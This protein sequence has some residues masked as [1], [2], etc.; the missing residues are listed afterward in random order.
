MCTLFLA[1][2]PRPD[3]SLLLLSNRDEF[4]ARPTEPAHWWPDQPELLAGRDG[5]QG[6]LWLGVNRRGRLAALTNVREGLAPAPAGAPSR[7]RLGLDCL[8]RGE[9]LHPLLDRLAEEAPVY[10]GF[11]LLLGEGDGFYWVSN[12]LP[13]ASTGH[14]ICHRLQP[15]L[16]GLS[17]GTLNEPWPKV[18]RGRAA[19]KALLEQPAL[20][21]PDRLLDL[22]MDESGAPDAEL[23]DTGVGLDHERRLAPLFIRGREYGTRS[24]TLLL[25]FP[26]GRWHWAGR[27]WGPDGAFV[28]QQQFQFQATR[29]T[30]A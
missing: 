4:H 1:L 20:P 6:G 3:L 5:L 23:P 13:G 17:N 30:R 27:E 8:T 29:E 9:G 18:R 22:L 2:A 21:D 12:R 10:P 7:G 24:S 19:L 16:H 25:A 11:N 28:A 26:D 15:G 14:S